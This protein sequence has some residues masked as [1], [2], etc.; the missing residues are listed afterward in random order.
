MPALGFTQSQLDALIAAYADPNSS[1]SVSIE[2]RS[3]S[4][5]RANK[6][7]LWNAIQEIQKDL[8]TQSGT[9]RKRY[10]FIQHSRA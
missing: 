10:T 1:G 7:E 2:G 8:A 5:T 4:W 6:A 9:G 3:H